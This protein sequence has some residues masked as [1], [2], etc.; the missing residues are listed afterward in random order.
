[1]GVEPTGT[2][3]AD[4]SNPVKKPILHSICRLQ[5]SQKITK[6]GEKTGKLFKVPETP[7]NPLISLHDNMYFG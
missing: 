1:M 7:S 3:F 4:R 6:N 2:G 5:Y